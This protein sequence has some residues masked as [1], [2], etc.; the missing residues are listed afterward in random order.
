ML[1]YIHGF[2]SSA[3]SGKARELGEW[4]ARRGLT[5]AYACPDLPHR[6][7]AA[8]ALLQDLIARGRGEV[9]LVGSSLGG[10]YAT[11][12]AEQFGVKAVLINPCVAC[13]DKL[14]DQV[15]I[16]QR[17]WH[18]GETYTFTPAHLDELRA[19]RVAR[20]SR[21]EHFLLLAET[22]DDVLDYREAVDYYRGARQIV[23]P[24]GDHGF[25]RFAEYIPT[26]IE[27]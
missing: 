20:P 19:L 8:I 21:P 23:L 5:E 2:N 1:I 18:S 26:L 11:W 24:G 6:P 9:K 22:G 7:A 14:A 16:E 3:R 15:G 12:L 27:F 25:T 10:F 17:N 4:L 13:D